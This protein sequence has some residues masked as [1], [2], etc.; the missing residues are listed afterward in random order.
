MCACGTKHLI[1]RILFANISYAVFNVFLIVLEILNGQSNKLCNL[2][3]IFYSKT[4][5]SS[6]RSTNTKTACYKGGSGVVWNSI[7]VSGNVDLVKSVLKLLTGN[8]CA[9]QVKKHEMVVGTAGY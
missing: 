6:G 9:D 4:S 2:V 7:L 3:E 1:Q 8:L 5:C